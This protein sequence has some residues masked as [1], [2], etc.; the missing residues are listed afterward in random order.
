M[1]PFS[2]AETRRSLLDSPPYINGYLVSEI[3]FLLDCI[4]LEFRSCNIS[5]I[6]GS[7]GLLPNS[8]LP[9][10]AL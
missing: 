5:V 8:E 9:D 1:R 7:F 3:S 10:E 4:S 2:K 6:F